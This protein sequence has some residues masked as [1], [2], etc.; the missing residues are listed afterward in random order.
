[1]N[2]ANMSPVLYSVP[3][4]TGSALAVPVTSP[5]A[6]ATRAPW[7]SSLPSFMWTLQCE[8]LTDYQT[9]TTALRLVLHCCTT[10]GPEAGD[11]EPHR[12]RQGTEHDDDGLPGCHAERPERL[13]TEIGGHLPGIHQERH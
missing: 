7:P 1:M 10:R 3:P 6:E 11:A 2:V 12:R 13:G 9:R 5:S 8:L 4:I